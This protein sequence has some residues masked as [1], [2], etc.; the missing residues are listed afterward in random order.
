MTL[1]E[2]QKFSKE[3]GILENMQTLRRTR[4]SV[5]KVAKK[6]WDFIMSLVDIEDEVLADNKAEEINESK[7]DGE[8]HTLPET[9]G[10]TGGPV[11][12]KTDLAE[13]EDGDDTT[14]S[15]SGE[16]ASLSLYQ[17]TVA[18]ATA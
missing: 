18:A 8:P 12:A 13:A 17:L 16:L 15:N 9:G 1:K 6:E 2:L 3:G 4:L 10:P 7:T 5:S 11:E 14:D